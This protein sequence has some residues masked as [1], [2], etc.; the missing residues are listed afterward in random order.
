VVGVNTSAQI[1]SAIVGRGVY[2]WLVPEFQATQDGTLHFHHLRDAGGGLV[3]V[4]TSL[5][6]HVGHLEAAAADPHG[7]SERGRRFVEVFVRPHGADAAATPRLV[8]ALEALAALG[9]AKPYRGPWWSVAVRPLLR[10]I[11]GVFERAERARE[12]QLAALKLDVRRR[13]A[14]A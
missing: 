9:P 12:A 6:E 8:E 2:T 5:D 4:A 3:Q 14:R 1:E 11:A 7:A 10:T 13:K